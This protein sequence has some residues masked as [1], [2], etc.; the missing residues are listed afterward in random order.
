MKTI[1]QSARLGFIGVG[2]F[3]SHNHLPNA[4]RSDVCHIRALCDINAGLLGERA[5][6]YQPDY[7][8][9]DYRRLL[10]DDD[11]DIVIIG[12]KQ[13]MHAQFACEALA[14]GKWALVEKPVGE[15]LAQMEQVV[16]AA[17]SAPGRLAVG[18]NRRFAPAV[19][20]AVKLMRPLA[21]PWLIYHRVINTSLDKATGFYGERAKLVYEGCHMFDLANHFIGA[22]PTAVIASGDGLR[23]DCVVC[24]YADGSRFVFME[25][26]MGSTQMEKE[27]IEL[28]REHSS[29]HIRDFTDMRVRGFRGEYDRIHATKPGMPDV[30][31]E[32]ALTYGNDYVDAT[33][34]NLTADAFALDTGDEGWGALPREEVRRVGMSAQAVDASR[35]LRKQV[36]ESDM[37]PSMVWMADKGWYGSLEH[38]ASSYIQGGEPENADA[39]DATVA[40]LTAMAALESIQSGRKIELRDMPGVTADLDLSRTARS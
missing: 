22:Y 27:S 39:L 21:G 23:N 33:R 17:A 36:M 2:S 32:D 25:G 28:F 24:E 31:V 3:I 26:S 6:L 1:F 12:T 15:T 7:A 8:T 10:D 4:H 35:R 20:D 5:E 30:F 11:V 9:D 18:H 29:I 13:D 34:A 40:C 37:P 14:A 38:F 16:T 19:V